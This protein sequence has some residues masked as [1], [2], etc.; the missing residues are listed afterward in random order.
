MKTVPHLQAIDVVLCIGLAAKLGGTD[1]AVKRCC[2]RLYKHTNKEIHPHI[3][4]IREAQH[5]K[6]VAERTLVE[7]LRIEEK[8]KCLNPSS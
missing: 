5:P 8:E 3:T 2:N 4:L 7:Y 6:Q 1:L